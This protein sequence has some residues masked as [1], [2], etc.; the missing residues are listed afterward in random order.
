MKTKPT[1]IIVHRIEFQQYERNLLDNLQTAYIGTKIVDPRDFERCFS[2][3]IFT[4][5]LLSISL[6]RGRFRSNEGNLRVYSRTPR[7]RL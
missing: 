2:D 3:G 6:W 1:Q 7:R 4:F 5:N